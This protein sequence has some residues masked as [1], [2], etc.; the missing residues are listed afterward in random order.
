MCGSGS[1][2]HGASTTL[3]VPSCDRRIAG[4]ERFDVVRVFIAEDQVLVRRGI[5]Q[6][7]LTRGV[8][9]AATTGEAAGLADAVIE[10]QA[11]LALLDIRMPPTHTDEGI[12][13]AVELRRRRPGFPVVVLSQYVEQLYFDELLARGEGGAGYLLKDRIFDDA[14]FVETLRAVASGETVVD[15]EVVG[16]KT[17]ALRTGLSPSS[18]RVSM[19]R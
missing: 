5:E 19:R 17:G 6:M 11:D 16:W 13:A 15:P 3:Y 8:T 1:P 12:R 2:L 4:D 14:R 10:S 7:L 18:H 9:I